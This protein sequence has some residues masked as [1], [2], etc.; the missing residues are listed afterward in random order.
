MVV[1]AVGAAQHEL[2]FAV[3]DGQ[4]FTTELLRH[5]REGRLLR[6]GCEGAETGGG[7]SNLS[8]ILCEWREEGDSP[9]STDEDLVLSY[10]DQGEDAFAQ[11]CGLRRKYGKVFRGMPWRN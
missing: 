11:L 5:S 7:V 8:S 10:Y 1:P 2:V 6:S 3:I 9:A 4:C